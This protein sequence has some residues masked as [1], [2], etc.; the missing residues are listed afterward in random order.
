MLQSLAVRDVVLI[1]RLDL[2]FRP[3]L[4]VLTGETGAGKS[5]L[6]DALGLALGA[7]ADST[8][9][10]KGAD[11]AQV[12]AV[13]SLPPDHPALALLAESDLGV[14]P[15]EPLILRRVVATD[16]RSRA[17]VNDQAVSIGLMRQVGEILVDIHGQFENQRLMDVSTHRR[18]L[19][20]HGGLAAD[21][22]MVAEAWRQWQDAAEARRAAEADGERA[23]RD[24]AY[25]RHALDELTAADPSPGEELELAEVR[26]ML[27][28]KE[29]ILE[30][31]TAAAGELAAGRGADGALNTAARH[32]ERV[33]EVAGGGL[34]AAIAAIDRAAVETA[35]AIQLIDTATRSM[36]LD[37]NRLESVEARLFALRALA[38]KHAVP[39]EGLADLRRRIADQLAGIEDGGAALAQLARREAEARTAYVAAATKLGK[40]RRRA[41]GRLEKAVAGELEPLRL[42][43]ARFT[44]EIE[45]L[46]ES[47]WG[48]AG[49]ER[50]VFRV[51]TNPGQDPGPLNRI[52][53]G[54]ELARFML[55][56]KMV[57]A[58]ADPVPTLVFDEVDSGVGGAV[59][60]AVGERL[61]RLSEEFQVL[62]VTHS[63]QVAARGTHHWR[64]SKSTTAPGTQTMVDAL[65]VGDRQEEIARMLAG[66]SIT[67]EARA[68]AAS[69]MRGQAG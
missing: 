26:A 67:D 31:L 68:A 1:D 65:D 61:A 5:I 59:A 52:S 32:L 62:V 51:A 35:E 36:D 49:Q 55:A 30:A 38:R 53:S 46:D 21:V 22:E 24:E 41:A 27:M 11:R 37:S 3:R 56:L 13:F 39:V 63:P 18:L 50:V 25:L 69:L 45:A 19:D 17:F 44:A 57:L 34:D 10:R 54:G 48:G 40:A 14:A 7:R 66:A 64:V 4:S 42:G 33:A 8:L 16:G 6:L 9:V 20:A 29:K 15:G 12:T 2:E 28:H 58:H 43:G 23:Q 60:A 47:E